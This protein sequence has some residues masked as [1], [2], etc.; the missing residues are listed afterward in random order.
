MPTDTSRPWWQG[1]VLYQVYLRSFADSNGDGTGDIAGVIDH[2]DHLEW[3][4]VDGIWLSPVTRSPNADWGYDVSDYVAVAD[5]LGTDGELDALIAAAGRRS[6]RVLLD[7]VP[8][9]TSVAHP[10]FVDS[11]SSR[12][13]VHRDWYVWADGTPE[14]SPPNNWISS[15][16]GPAWT[17]D[18][19]TGQYY[20]HNHLAEQPDL[21]WWNE[22]VRR[23]FDEI[24]VTWFDRGVSGFRIDVCNMVVKDALLR[25]NPPATDADSFTEQ[26]FGQRW[27]YNC[28]R[29]ELHDVLRRWRS[30]ADRFPGRVLIGETPD[31]DIDVLAAYYGRG[32]DEL[33]LAFDFPFI[34]APLD[35]DA[36]RRI[37]AGVERAL[38]P[39]AWP[40]W[41]GSNHDMS[42]LATRWAQGDP[43]K[44]RVALAMLLTLRGTPVLYQGDE[45]GLEDVEVP[46]ERFR[47]PLGVRYWPA[48]AGRDA[49]RTPMHWRDV[50]GG[51]FTDPGVEPWLPFGDLASCNVEDQRRDPSSMLHF[52][53]SL[54]ALRRTSS[55]LAFGG[56][57][58]LDSPAGSWCWTRGERTVVCLT[59]T[60][61]ACSFENLTGTVLLCSDRTRDG[62]VLGGGLRLGGWQAAVLECHRG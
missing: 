59:L 51:G 60:D 40:A 28:G 56:Y 48:Y 3:L 34:S 37:V 24:M 17:F 62:E 50:E 39:G 5:E 15:F 6:I 12:S 52:V 4:G 49:M 9:H 31:E 35:A 61:S 36:L 53:R 55:D 42:R 57:R 47:D 22:E 7:L 43:A 32:S 41:T 45:I 13:S 58:A 25:D 1:G 44:A 26:M 16:G 46:P 18:E 27:L 14:G 8:N 33:H 54:I 2:L 20:L 19:A 38:P 23:T 21:N 10:W 11:R 30:L 29:P